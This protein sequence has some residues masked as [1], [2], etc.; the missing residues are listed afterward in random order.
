[1]YDQFI[2]KFSLYALLFRL[3][4]VSA[5]MNWTCW[6]NQGLERNYLCWTL[7]IRFLTTAVL[8]SMAV[9]NLISLSFCPLSFPLQQSTCKNKISFIVGSLAREL[10]VYTKAAISR[11]HRTFIWQLFYRRSVAENGNELMRP[12]LHEFLTSAYEVSF[13]NS[14]CIYN[15]HFL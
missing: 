3:Q 8:V 5:R 10:S 12:Y 1:M 7:I 9:F 4:N 2:I 11:T 14:L 15:L 13:M 6:M